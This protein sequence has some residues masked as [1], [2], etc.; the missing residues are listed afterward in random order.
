MCIHCG[1]EISRKDFYEYQK[2]KFNKFMYDTTYKLLESYGK[3]QQE[4]RD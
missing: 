1:L 2:F 3:T 4:L